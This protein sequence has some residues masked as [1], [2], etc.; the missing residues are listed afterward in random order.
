MFTVCP[1]GL[2]P[3]HLS[4]C[5]RYTVIIFLQVAARQREVYPPVRRSVERHLRDVYR[6]V[7]AHKHK[8]VGSNLVG[9]FPSLDNQFARAHKYYRVRRHSV[10]HV[11]VVFYAAAQQNVTI[12]YQIIHKSVHAANITFLFHYS[13]FILL[14]ISFMASAFMGVMSTRSSDFTMCS[15][16]CL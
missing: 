9:A 4:A 15:V 1:M 14:N 11:H 16:P 3:P 2:M 10:L 12:A 8:V 7:A 13:F 6:A 5:C